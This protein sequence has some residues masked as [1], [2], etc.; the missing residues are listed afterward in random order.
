[1]AASMGASTAEHSEADW[2]DARVDSM[3][4][5]SADRTDVPTAETLVATRVDSTEVV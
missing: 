1:M 2:V 5:S 4:V 3:A